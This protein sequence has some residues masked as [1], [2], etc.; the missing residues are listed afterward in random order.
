[1]AFVFYQRGAREIVEVVDLL[2]RDPGIYSF[3]E[4]EILFDADGDPGLLQLVEETQKHSD[5]ASISSGFEKAE[6][7]AM[8][9][10]LFMHGREVLGLDLF[11]MVYG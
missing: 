11:I 6:R 9:I 10:G 5:K 1:M 8:G 2:V 7:P 4:G 3:K